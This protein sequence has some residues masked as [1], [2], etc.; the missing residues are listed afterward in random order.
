MLFRAKNF[1]AFTG[2]VTAISTDRLRDIDNARN[3]RGL[4]VAYPPF[5]QKRGFSGT[6][7]TIWYRVPQQDKCAWNL[8]SGRPKSGPVERFNEATRRRGGTV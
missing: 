6:V 7:Q 8:C 3:N 4:S 5:P 2:C 1:R